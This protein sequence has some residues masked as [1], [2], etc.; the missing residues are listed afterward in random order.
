ML[1][2][3]SALDGRLHPGR[4]GAQVEAVSLTLSERPLGTFVQL[5][6]WRDSFESVAT[7]VMQRLGFG[8][9][10]DFRTAQ[11]AGDAVAFRVAPERI[12]LN[13][14]SP[15]LW[16]T[17]APGIDRA[18][19]P[20]LDLSHAR[21][22]VRVGGSSATALMARLLP[23]DFDEVAFGPDHFVQSGLHSV[24]VLVHRRSRPGPCFDIYI[25]S[26]FAVSV[27]EVIT[28]TAAPFG[29]RVGGTR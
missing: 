25:P 5:S 2:Y 6:G 15:A 28:D 13:V 20:T 29:Y 11:T 7:P 10:G 24:A 12:L 19:T 14:P 3:R 22:V 21:T 1:E 9:I 23:I 18:T 8:S 27:W 17:V 26:S 16:A 4:F